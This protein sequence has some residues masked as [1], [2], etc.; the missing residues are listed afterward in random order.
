MSE[1]PNVEELIVQLRGLAVRNM[2]KAEKHPYDYRKYR[3]DGQI[4]GLAAEALAYFLAQERLYTKFK[5]E[6]ND[7]SKR[8]HSDDESGNKDALVAGTEVGQVQ[9]GPVLPEAG[10]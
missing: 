10:G 1:R 7:V 3:A 4:L 5:E 6:V 8:S 2:T 9:A